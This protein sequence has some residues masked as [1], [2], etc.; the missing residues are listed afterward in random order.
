[1]PW[2][3][4]SMPKGNAYRWVHCPD[5]LSAPSLLCGERLSTWRDPVSKQPRYACQCSWNELQVLGEPLAKKADA[6]LAAALAMIH[7]MQGAGIVEIL[8]FDPDKVS[9]EGRG[10]V[11]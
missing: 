8:P 4:V 10:V 5:H 2:R 9:Y 1:M 7:A 3:Y 6:K 11:S